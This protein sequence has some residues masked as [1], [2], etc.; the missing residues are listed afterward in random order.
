MNDIIMYDV[1][2]QARHQADAAMERHHKH[3]VVEQKIMIGTSLGLLVTGAYFAMS[4][5]HRNIVK[6]RRG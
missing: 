4:T 1:N 3:A 2:V 6:I 5:L